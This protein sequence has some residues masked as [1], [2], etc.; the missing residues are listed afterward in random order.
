M[1]AEPSTPT[2]EVAGG[3]PDLAWPRAERRFRAMGSDAQVL[4]VGPGAERRAEWAAQRIDRLEARWSRFLPG[5]EVSELNRRAGHP[6]PVSPD[7]TVLVDRALA[8]HR[9][10]GGRFDPTLGRELAD[11][12]YDRPFDRLAD[13]DR[14]GSAHPLPPAVAVAADRGDGRAALTVDPVAGT[15]TVGRGRHFDPGGIGKGLAADLVVEE[16]LAGG[17][18]GA[19]VNLG[20]DL[21]VWG[22]PPTGPTWVVAVEHPHCGTLAVVELVEGGLATSTTLRRRWPGRGDTCHHHLLDPA[23]GRPHADGAD[24]VSVIAA[25]AWEAEV[26]ATALI[27]GPPGDPGPAAPTAL[28]VRGDGPACRHGGFE[29]FE[30]ARP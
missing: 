22:I 10:T 7:T 16:L 24:F 15:V 14:P 27:G 18:W 4:V 23:T 11:L 9:L 26:W 1:A 12:G 3:G 19:L 8:A 20:G 21:R 5:S 30:R 28:L 29:R 2:V 6:V 13:R 17:A 25:R